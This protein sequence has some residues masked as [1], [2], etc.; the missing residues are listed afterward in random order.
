MHRP[1][2][3]LL[4]IAL[5]SAWVA[6]WIWPLEWEGNHALQG[7]CLR[8]G[9]VMGALWLALPQLHR[10]PGWLVVLT[11]VVAVVVALQPRRAV[12]LVPVLIAAWLL[13]PRKR[14]AANRELRESPQPV[15][16]GSKTRR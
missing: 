5:L 16:S 12:V 11:T 1:T 2:V 14:K 6:L 8:V 3:G 4:A 15:A 13:R 10:V 9:L 7:A